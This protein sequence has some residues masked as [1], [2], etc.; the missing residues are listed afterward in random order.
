MYKFY[1]VT[2]FSSYILFCCR[3]I[4]CY[5]VVDGYVM[6]EQLGDLQ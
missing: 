3:W 1:P 5:N 4:G 2:E 6:T